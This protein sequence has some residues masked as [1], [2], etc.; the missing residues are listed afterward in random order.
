MSRL[1]VT[2]S[3]GK[4]REHRLLDKRTESCPICETP[5]KDF[6]GHWNMFH[7]SMSSS[8]CG[9]SYQVKDYSPPDDGEN[10]EEL[11][12]WLNDPNYVELTIK[13][14]WVEPLHQAIKQTGIKDI[15]NERVDMVAN[16][17]FKLTTKTKEKADE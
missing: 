2:K 9:A 15:R 5:L 11:F 8:C 13:S 1:I 17:I 16:E 7:G 12:R 6:N 10:F 4:E 14:E 3:K